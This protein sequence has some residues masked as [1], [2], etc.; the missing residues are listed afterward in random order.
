MSDLMK[1]RYEVVAAVPFSKFKVGDILHKYSYP[2]FDMNYTWFSNEMFSQAINASEID[3][4]PHLFRKLAWHEKRDIKDMPE[5]VK[6]QEEEKTEIV[7]VAEWV[8]DRRNDYVCKIEHEYYNAI[9]YDTDIYP[10]TEQE[11]TDF[12]N[13]KKQQS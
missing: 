4:Y 6:M 10:A 8:F 1:E 5:Y 9:S 7:K 12:V 2:V 13:S 3:K 11:Y